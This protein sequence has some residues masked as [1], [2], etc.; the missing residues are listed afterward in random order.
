M[1]RLNLI[2][3]LLC[4]S[5]LMFISSCSENPIGID[6]HKGLWPLDLGNEWIYEIIYPEWYNYD[7]IMKINK[8]SNLNINSENYSVSERIYY[9]SVDP[10]PSHKSIYWTGP[11]G[12][13]KMGGVSPNDTLKMKNLFL[14]YPAEIGETWEVPSLSYSQSDEEF[15]IKDTLTYM[16]VE[17]NVDFETPAG[18]FRCYVYEYTRK[19]EG[20]ATPWVFKF[21]YAPGIGLIG[22]V[23]TNIYGNLKEKLL[24][25]SYSVN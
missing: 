12:V 18:V 19:L 5:F 3:V 8:K 2:M 25:K 4:G 6:D 16:L 22:N 7:I 14:K 17:K 1:K 23:T 13:Y 20:S 10:V 9:A 24:L 15:Y 21:Y 11:G